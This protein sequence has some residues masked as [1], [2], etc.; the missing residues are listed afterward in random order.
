VFEQ[1]LPIGAVY[2]PVLAL[3]EPEATLGQQVP[4]AA[5]TPARGSLLNN[6]WGHHAD[7]PRRRSGQGPRGYELGRSGPSNEALIRT[8]TSVQ[9]IARHS[10]RDLDV[11]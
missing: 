10:A 1:P 9:D 4:P 11:C 7:V 5:I 8:L 3:R 6:A 2:V